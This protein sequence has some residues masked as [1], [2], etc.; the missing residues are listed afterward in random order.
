MPKLRVRVVILILVLIPLF[1]LGCPAKEPG[2]IFHLPPVP[3]EKKLPVDYVFLI[4]NSGSIPK[5]EART[6]AREAIKAFTELVEDGDRLSFILFDQEAE[7]I[8]SETIAKQA[9]RGRLQAALESKLTFGGRFTDLSKGTALLEEKKSI[10]FRK[11]GA[12]KPAVLLISDGKLEPRGDLKAAYEKL[13]QDWQSLSN[14][15]PFYTLGLGETDINDEFL[16]TSGKRLLTR[17]AEESGGEFYHVRSVNDLVETCGGVLRRTKGYGELAGKEVFDTDESTL[18][19]VLV[20]IKRLPER[21]LY[22]TTDIR[23]KNPAG[24][25][26]NFGEASAYQ[27]GQTRILWREGAYYDLIVVDRPTMGKWELSLKTGG[28]PKA[29]ALIRNQVHLR[30]LPQKEYWDQEKKIVMAWLY[31]ERKNALSERSCQVVL[32]FDSLKAF[33]KSTNEIPLQ[34]SKKATYPTSLHLQGK[35]PPAGDYLVE[36]RAEDNASFFSRKSPPIPVKV[37]KAYFAFKLLEGLIP[38]WPIFWKGVPFTGEIDSTHQVYPRFQEPPKIFLHLVKIE[39]KKT[40]PLPKVELPWKRSDGKIF[41]QLSRPDLE[42]GQYG[43]FYSME[44]RLTSG[45]DVRVESPEFNF[46]LFW[47]IW[48][49]IILGGIFVVI[50]VFV[51]YVTRPKLQGRLE[52][53]KPEGR[54]SINLTGHKKAKK[55]FKGDSLRFGS[56]GKDLT[57][58]EESSFTLSACRKK[59][60]K[61]KVGIGNFSL[62]REE[63]TRPITTGDLFRGDILTFADKKVNYGIEVFSPRRFPRRRQ[64]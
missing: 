54:L 27:E 1:L 12:A 61:I 51:L 60:L 52:F 23:L 62:T 6:F 31:D 7:L 26:M 4:D 44:G 17:M 46:T 43:G 35:E 11:L 19:L 8:A 38:K 39:E 32:K 29:V 41:Y 47:P 53:L 63:Q 36:I 33:P 34:K 9:D 64:R 21:Q 50:V 16:G 30:Y 18:R 40:V 49:W 58:L 56:G 45:K 57:E 25:E 22:K 14:T 24:R 13:I 20:V 5:G 2:P 28:G 3:E 10:L 59:G 37:K 55:S 15:I 42:L 48:V